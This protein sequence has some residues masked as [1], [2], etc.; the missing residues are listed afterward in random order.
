MTTKLLILIRIILLQHITL[1]EKNSP[2]EDDD[3]G[4]VGTRPAINR[5]F[6]QLEY[7]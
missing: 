6:N 4:I 3:I 5:N 1:H 7:T 2:V